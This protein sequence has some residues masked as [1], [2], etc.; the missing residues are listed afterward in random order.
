MLTRRELGQ[1]PTR[2]TAPPQNPQLRRKETS[3]ALQ[4]MGAK[5]FASAA[6]IVR[7]KIWH[8]LSTFALFSL[9]PLLLTESS[10]P[11]TCVYMMHFTTPTQFTTSAFFFPPLLF[12]YHLQ[13]VHNVFPIW[14]CFQKHCCMY[15]SSQ[16]LYPP[17][18]AQGK[19]KSTNHSVNNIIKYKCTH[20]PR[21][22]S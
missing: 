13:S 20:F 1:P 2:R 18:I 17:T 22:S 14:F 15:R 10:C 16:Y 21:I 3:S 4:P 8:F 9:W 5:Q 7:C 12:C 11:N 19:K 6:P